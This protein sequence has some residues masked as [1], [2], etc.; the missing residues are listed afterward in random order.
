MVVDAG[1]D[2]YHAGDGM[3]D[4]ACGVGRDDGLN[5]GFEGGGGGEG[6]EDGAVESRGDGGH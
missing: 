5:G 3:G 2:G 4:V 6:Q 1:V